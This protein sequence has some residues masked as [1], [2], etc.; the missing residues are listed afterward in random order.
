VSRGAKA[1]AVAWLIAAV[2]YFYQYTL[3]SAPAVMT[4]Q[5]SEAFGLTSMGVASMVE[6][7]LYGVG[8]ALI[9]CFV[10]KETGPAAH[11]APSTRLESP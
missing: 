5:L 3:R 6:P 2:Y 10:L 8:L 11:A 7:M 4:P 9:L 1:A